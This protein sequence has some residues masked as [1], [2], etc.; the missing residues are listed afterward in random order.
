MPI[1]ARL[2]AAPSMD[3]DKLKVFHAAAEA[4]SFTHA[5]DQLGLS[6]SAVSPLRPSRWPFSCSNCR[7]LRPLRASCLAV[8][9]HPLLLVL[10]RLAATVLVIGLAKSATIPGTIA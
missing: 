2:T 1:T 6:Q 4:G 10:F 9:A 7:S 5:G 8:K 3:W